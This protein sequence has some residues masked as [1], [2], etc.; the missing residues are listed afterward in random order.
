MEIYDHA[1]LLGDF[2]ADLHR[3]ESR[4]SAKMS[5]FLSDMRSLH[6]LGEKQLLISTGNTPSP[7]K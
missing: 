3:N 2:T 5:S 1:V 6:L 4:F 7:S